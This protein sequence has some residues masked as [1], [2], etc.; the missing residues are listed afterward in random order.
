MMI[1][2]QVVNFY[3][4]DKKKIKGNKLI[5]YQA[6]TDNEFEFLLE[7]A[8]LDEKSFPDSIKNII[9]LGL[10]YKIY[11]HVTKSDKTSIFSYATIIEKNILKLSA[12]HDKND[13]LN[14]ICNILL[15]HF[16]TS[17]D[18]S[19]KR[20]MTGKSQQYFLN[21]IRSDAPIMF[22]S[23]WAQELREEALTV[24][25]IGCHIIPKL[26]FYTTSI[27]EMLQHI[28]SIAKLSSRNQT[29]VQYIHE[30]KTILKWAQA[31]ALIPTLPTLSDSKT[32]QE[33][34]ISEVAIKTK[35]GKKSKDK[36]PNTESE[37]I[38][39]E[40][41]QQSNLQEE[42][43]KKKQAEALEAQNFLEKQKKAEARRLKE[44]AF[45]KE[46][47]TKEA[48]EK[49]E[50]EKEKI[51]RKETRKQLELKATEEAAKK[52]AEQE[53]RT[54]RQAEKRA[55]KQ[56]EEA[57]VKAEKLKLIA[58]EQAEKEA[59]K[60]E[61]LRQLQLQEIQ[62]QAEKER[63]LAQLALEAQEKQVALIKKNNAALEISVI[64]PLREHHYQRA[65][66]RKQIIEH[67]P[68]SFLKYLKDFSL[69][70]FSALEISRDN[71][72]TLKSM[73][74]PPEDAST[75]ELFGSYVVFIASLRLGFPID[76]IRSPSDIDI[77]IK[78]KEN[79][80]TNYTTLV[81]YLLSLGFKLK[82]PLNPD[83]FLERYIQKR[84]KNGGFMSLSKPPLAGDPQSKEMELSIIFSDVYVANTNPFSLLKHTLL[85]KNNQ[86][87]F[88]G[89]NIQLNLEL[90]NDIIEN[91]FQ[92]NMLEP[93]DL[94]FKVHN[95]F[96]RAI[97]NIECWN[98]F[99]NMN[100]G[101]MHEII[102]RLSF[103]TDYF[104]I[105][106]HSQKHIKDCYLEIAGLIHQGYFLK[107]AST[108]I[109]E[110]FLQAF[111]KV[112]NL[113]SKLAD[114]KEILDPKEITA[115]TQK[116]K[117]AL[118]KHVAQDPKSY[119][120]LK[121]KSE[122]CEIFYK[123]VIQLLGTLEISQPKKLFLLNCQKERNSILSGI[124]AIDLTQV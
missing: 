120:E 24:Y 45:K 110:G 81:K 65:E 77:R 115:A 90:G 3:K 6:L 116:I 72:Q 99:F 57:R 108:L 71:L 47:Q 11:K 100:T 64:K 70:N 8:D 92:C 12:T 42:E 105:R 15:F 98:T 33:S 23:K 75:L 114:K 13:I 74:T 27:D 111:F 16:T 88:N 89:D 43:E 66:E 59:I 20:I 29:K 41:P 17:S 63:E 49:L 51:I 58:Q 26:H 50:R 52:K 19:H 93:L 121:E 40:A 124:P 83:Q 46:L 96:P 113:E 104:I 7:V 80:L 56:A 30:A 48:A 85:I 35:K 2:K 62:I 117:L 5:P 109:I 54:Q 102:N 1:I 103:I 84:T 39:T 53:E 37:K 76:K 112:L 97:K 21:A 34:A 25:A 18:N 107:P 79:S 44:E 55:A 95:F 101:S 82:F 123:K 38:P 69:D 78:L 119:T 36:N 10:Y 4:P 60:A 61:A 87:S 32:L 9:L 67:R 14:E 73:S 31:V 68:F 106:F 118:E 22:K 91:N 94:N 28:A 122:V 86:A